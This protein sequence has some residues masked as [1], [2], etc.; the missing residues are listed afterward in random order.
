MGGGRG[1]GI[2]FSSLSASKSN[3]CQWQFI[4]RWHRFVALQQKKPRVVGWGSLLVLASKHGET[5]VFMSLNVHLV[6]SFF[7]PLAVR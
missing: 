3:A 2:I 1:G 7:L 5:S 6:D 4:T